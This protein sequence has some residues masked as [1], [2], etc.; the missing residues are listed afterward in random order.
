[1]SDI[2]KSYDGNI[3]AFESHGFYKGKLVLYC[4]RDELYLADINDLDCNKCKYYLDG[5]SKE[6]EEYFD[7]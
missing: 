6:A 5:E 1:M 4:V 7:E 3:C 2:I